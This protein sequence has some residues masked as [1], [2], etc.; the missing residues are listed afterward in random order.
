MWAPP[1]S[2]QGGQPAWD[3]ERAAWWL[4]DA[5][6][7]EKQLQPVSDVVFDRAFL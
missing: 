3:E 1:Q 2:R 6:A 5:D 4:A 7:L